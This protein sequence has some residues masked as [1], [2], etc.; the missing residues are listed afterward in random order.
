M[1]PSPPSDRDANLGVAEGQPGLCEPI[2]LAIIECPESQQYVAL[3]RPLV[4]ISALPM[5]GMRPDG[6]RQA[7]LPSPLAALISS[8]P[9]R[10]VAAILFGN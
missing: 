10:C 3:S 9:S 6:G 1:G 4:R 5:D 7:S 2:G 8:L